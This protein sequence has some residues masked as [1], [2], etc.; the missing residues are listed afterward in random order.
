M[1]CCADGPPSASATGFAMEHTAMSGTLDV[2]AAAKR[3]PPGIL[4]VKQRISTLLPL[5]ASETPECEKVANPLKAF[6]RCVEGEAG[7][8]VRYR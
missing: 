5:Q 6:R 7:G 1:G 4:G 8:V 2:C 3:L